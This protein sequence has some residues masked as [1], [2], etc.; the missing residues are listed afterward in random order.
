MPCYPAFG[1]LLGLGLA[2]GPR[3]WVHGGYA[4]LAVVGLLAG[5]VAAVILYQVRGVPAPGDISS[6]LTQNPEAY[7]LSLGHLRDLTLAAFA[8]LRAPLLAA[9]LALVAGAVGAWVTRRGQLGPLF[10]A[11]MMVVLLQAAHF[12]MKVFDPYLSS[13]PLAEALLAAPAGQL[14]IEGHYYPASSLVFYTNRAALLYHG[15][16]DNLV[17]GA[18][19]PGVP[20]VFLEDADL[21]R[22]WKEP[23]RLYL[24]APEES[25][26]RLEGLLGAVTVFAA[27]GGKLLLTNR[28]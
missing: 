21:A 17:Y 23:R 7:T 15:K 14:I 20:P 27:R 8:Y 28:P 16:A 12:A 11:G 25:R 22:L 13:R 26:R 19:A 9:G 18:A 5:T 1:V 6:A 10:L 2:A 4:A 24:I 3:R